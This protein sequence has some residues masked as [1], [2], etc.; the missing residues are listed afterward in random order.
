MLT[1]IILATLLLSAISLIS[2]FFLSL[3][4]ETLGK[5]THYLVAL[6]AGAMMGAAFLHMLPESLEFLDEKLVF[7]TTLAGFMAFFILEKV[8][9][10]HHC[11]NVGQHKHTLGYMNLAGDGLHNFIDGLVVAA[12]FMVDTSVGIVV[13]LA[14]A[15]HELPQ[16]ISDFGVLLHSG[17]E[18]IKALKANAVISLTMVLGGILGYFLINQVESILPYLMAFA[19]GGFIYISAS[20]LVPELKEESSLKKSA[21]HILVFLAGI[22]MTMLFERGH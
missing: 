16:E 9:H 22:I 13:S 17:W 1:Q 21:L 7:A 18:R 15:S 10:W 3:K 20:D 11:H 12:A 19:A 6:S 5:I 4:K 8:L 2:I 14:V